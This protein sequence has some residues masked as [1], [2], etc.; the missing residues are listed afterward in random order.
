MRKPS[1]RSRIARTAQ[2]AACAIRTVR[3][4][5]ARANAGVMFHDTR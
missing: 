3:A 4:L 5:T 2:M 1:N